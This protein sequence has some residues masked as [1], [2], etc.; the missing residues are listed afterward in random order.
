M[1]NTQFPLTNLVYCDADCSTTCPSPDPSFCQ[2][3][4]TTTI[5]TST[6]P[7]MT[8]TSSCGTMCS[9]IIDGGNPFPSTADTYPGQLCTT[10]SNNQTC[11][12]AVVTCT[13]GSVTTTMFVQ[14]LENG[15]IV[16]NIYELFFKNEENL[17]S[18]SFR[19]RPRSSRDDN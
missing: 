8:T 17:D 19:S 9:F 18:N 2:T 16:R 15:V 5:I 6:T 13:G 4:T 14:L 3:T 1:G 7:E 12:T 10:Y 11:N